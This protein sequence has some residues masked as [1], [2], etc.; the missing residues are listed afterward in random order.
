[1]LPPGQCGQSRNKLWLGA[2][3]DIMGLSQKGGLMRRN[4]AILALA[5]LSIFGVVT[6]LAVI[7]ATAA[8]WPVLGVGEPLQPTRTQRPLPTRYHL[9]LPQ[10]SVPQP[11]ATPTM[12]LAQIQILTATPSPPL[13][14]ARAQI[15]TVE[16]TRSEVASSGGA[17]S[18]GGACRNIVV[19]TG[20]QLTLNGEPFRFIGTNASFLL[21]G[22]FPLN[23][24]EPILAFMSE[25]FPNPVLRVWLL[26][27]YSQSRFQ[28]M[29]DLGRKYGVRFVVSLD[30]YYWS[31]SESWF[32]STFG[33]EYLPH[34]EKVVARFRDRPEILMWELMNE[35]N[36]GPEGDRQS[37]L[38]A[39]YGWA[40]KTSELIKALDPCHLVSIGTSGVVTWTPGGEG[41]FRRMHALPSVDI[42]SVHKEVNK[43]MDNEVRLAR[44]LGKPLFIGE[45][46][47][48][49]YDDRCQ[50]IRQE[51][52]GE[53]AD[54]VERDIR[55]TFEQGSSG[56]L[57]WQYAPGPVDMGGAIQWFC[58]IY[59]YLRDDPTHARIRESI[60][61]I[62]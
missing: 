3:Y 40:K 11:S 20:D 19:R 45:A 57:L 33:M 9:S 39:E 4:S 28:R 30:N 26:P 13:P 21:E 56:Y 14:T 58:G 23:E 35:P 55:A 32:Q 50:V 18:A 61:P 29:L 34:V 6:V 37:C 48:Q 12:S 24:I 41:N 36:C 7:A 62:E 44:E 22:Y 10:I 31:K 8:L 51:M 2:F 38:D 49:V 59:D 43:E 5:A 53:R 42:I 46:Y 52:L 1:M 25:T 60:W 15:A 16:P 17:A 27:G 47:Y 54:A